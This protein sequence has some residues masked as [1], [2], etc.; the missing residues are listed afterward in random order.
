MDNACARRVTASGRSSVGPGTGSREKSAVIPEK[1]DANEEGYRQHPGPVRQSVERFVMAWF[2][3]EISERT[4][5]KNPVG[6]GALST[7][8]VCS[9]GVAQ[10]LI[11]VAAYAGPAAATACPP[12]S[13]VNDQ[14]LAANPSFEDVGENGSPSVCSAPCTIAKESAADAWTMH[15][16]NFGSSISTRLEPHSI[17]GNKRV[18]YGTDPKRHAKMLHVI[19]N[20]SESGVLQINRALPSKIMFQV[21]VYVLKGKVAI[22]PHGGALGPVAW[23]TK[24]DQ[25][26]ELRV[27][28][29]GTVPTDALVIYNQARGGGNFYVDRVE[30]RETP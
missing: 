7:L 4:G 26:E 5:R 21:W 18:P 20:G 1:G 14:N 27:C 10:L 22:Q 17:L 15:T 30:V 3:K 16:D 2:G 19:A 6:V 29:D 11:P 25:W 23:S 24:T 8:L 13:F 12:S 9:L 28:T